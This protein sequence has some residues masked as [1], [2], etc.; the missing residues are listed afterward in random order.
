MQLSRRFKTYCSRHRSRLLVVLLLVVS[1]T[2]F[3]IRVISGG[4]RA[5]DGIWRWPD[6]DLGKRSFEIDFPPVEIP[7]ET[8]ALVPNENLRIST[9]TITL[10]ESI[11]ENAPEENN[12]SDGS[13]QNEATL[14]PSHQEQIATVDIQSLLTAF[15]PTDAPES[16]RK[17]IR[18]KIMQAVKH[19][20]ETGRYLLILDRS[21]QSLN[22]VN[23]VQVAGGVTDL[24]EEIRKEIQRAP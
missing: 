8:P 10:S 9:G 17:A 16:T 15:T 13:K 22:G 11:N 14:S 2:Y 20:A 12:T 5:D 18:E 23:V 4:S 6:L 21:G 7:I 19:Y 3:G 1:A 24:T